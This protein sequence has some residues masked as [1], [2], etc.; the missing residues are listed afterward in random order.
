MPTTTAL[1]RVGAEVPC[2]CY[3]ANVP[4]K[5]RT[6]LV[7]VDF[8]G[9]IKVRVEAHPD[10]PAHKAV[11][12]KVVGHE[13]SAEHENLGRITIKQDDSE[14]TPDSLLKVVQHF[15]P[16][17]SATMFLSFTLTIQSPPGATAARE[18]LVLRTKEPAVLQSPNLDRFPPDGDLY[19]LQNPIQLVS[20]DNL[21]DVI[22]T[23]DKFPVSVG[24]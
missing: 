23:I 6:S 7:T 22:A 4:L 14:A 8:K 12:L 20:P 1:P 16:Q 11:V 15:P 17:L 5:I 13:V 24:G 3:A 2:S 18:P 21:D 9:G 10:E 19:R